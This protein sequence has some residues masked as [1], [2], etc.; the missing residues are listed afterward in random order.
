[1]LGVAALLGG[2][3]LIFYGV[4]LNA[5]V[6]SMAPGRIPA[7][8]RERT[9]V[10]VWAQFLGDEQRYFE[11]AVAAF[12]RSQQEVYIRNISTAEDDTKV[13]R[14]IS[15][16]VP[17]DLCILWNPGYVGTLAATGAIQPLDRFFEKSSLR[18]EEFVPA[19]LAGGT[20]EG[21][22]YS[23]PYLV[24]VHCL[25]WTEKAFREAGLDVERGPRTLGELDEYIK[26][27]TRFDQRGKLLRLGFE[28]P[29]PEV[30]MALWGVRF[31]DA[32]K[33][34]ITCDEP[35]AVEAL[36]WRIHLEDLQGG[37]EKVAAFQAGFG[38]FDSP[39]HQ[40]FH[41]LVAMEGY[42]E[43]WPGYVQRYGPHVRYRIGALPYPENYPELKGL[44]YM[45]GNYVCMP[46]G[47][48]HPQEAWRFM[49]WTHSREGQ[50]TFAEGMRN[51]PDIVSV[52]KEV[53]PTPEQ[54]RR[55]NLIFVDP[56]LPFE[57]QKARAKPIA[58]VR[59]GL[60]CQAALSPKWAVFPPLPVNV[61]YKREL[62]TAFQYAERGTK[63]P[64][65]ALA[66]CQ[67]RVQAAL[68]DYLTH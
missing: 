12:N 62:L 50:I 61:L 4:R 45:V 26:K 20:Y 1:M 56:G 65:Q 19:A 46:S 2:A 42:G 52:V 31:Y 60:A 28:P 55:V 32:Q 51:C 13:F 64:E 30:C 27:L 53:A 38:N 16:G 68:E 66:D 36:K 41:G 25:F 17:P 59:F 43:W 37:A 3:V 5:W 47:C 44:S 40:F 34:R 11:R 18:R 10:T 48:K 58:D 21:K 67:K 35:R 14:A 54:V 39:Q 63:T 23:L 15:A 7:W 8:A 49:E 57:E 33:R 29:E 9:V 6:D 22:L 24:D